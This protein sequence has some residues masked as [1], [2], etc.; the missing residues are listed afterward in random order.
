MDRLLRQ[1]PLEQLAAAPEPL[2]AQLLRRPHGGRGVLRIDDQERT[3]IGAQES[4]GVERLERR[5]LA[6]AFDRLPDRDER[7]HVRVLRPERPRDDRADVRHRHRLRRDVARVPV[8]LMAR[9]QD[10]PEVRRP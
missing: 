6:R 9:V 4:G 8:V 2:V 7:R 3:V 5:D 10:E 1:Q